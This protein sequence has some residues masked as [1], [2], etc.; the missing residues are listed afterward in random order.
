MLTTWLVFGC[1]YD[2]KWQKPIN[3]LN[4]MFEKNFVVLF[5]LYLGP[6]GR[7]LDR[8]SVLVVRLIMG[9]TKKNIYRSFLLLSSVWN[10]LCFSI[11]VRSVSIHLNIRQYT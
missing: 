7:L 10:R 5:G 4:W 3:L 11:A 1:C 2:V 9:L 6:T 8:I